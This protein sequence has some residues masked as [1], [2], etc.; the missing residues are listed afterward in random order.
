MKAD[1]RK[2]IIGIIS[3]VLVTASILG[4]FAI[5]NRFYIPAE[6]EGTLANPLHESASI[7]IGAAIAPHLLKTSTGY[8]TTASTHFNS[9]TAENVMKMG[10]IHPSENEYDWE[11]ADYLVEYAENH[12]IQIHG[13]C[14][15]W[16]QQ[17]PDWMENY[18]GTT[19][20]WKDMLKD[21]I[22]T[23]VTRYKD[24]ITSWDVVNEAVDGTGY[25]NTIWYENIGP[26][27]IKLAFQ[28][29]RD[30][31]PNVKLYYNDYSLCTNLDKLAFVTDMIENLI[32]EGVPV[33]G[34]GFQA[35]LTK[36]YA[37]YE[38]IAAA[39]T[40]I[41]ELDID[42]RVSELDISMNTEKLYHAYTDHLV[43]EQNNCYYDVV[44]GFSTAN[45]LTGIT[46]WGI[47]DENS[48][49]QYFRGLDWPLLFDGAFNPKPAAFSF[50][51]A[52]TQYL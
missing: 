21:H 45:R 23:V 47:D 52:L 8:N 33:D 12:S 34:L 9:F 14:L 41:N 48:W 6:Y 28:W 11:S 37:N 32:S 50:Q 51:T 38:T 40:Y 3:I 20:D 17:V 10:I 16:H 19:Q 5:A 44:K 24:N 25:R 35:H 26:D 2:K 1:L 4:G 43:Q 30:A 7:P 31:D 49:I 18:Q 39:M 46:L 22:Q 29:A 42:I 15:V 13:H 36:H 27:Y